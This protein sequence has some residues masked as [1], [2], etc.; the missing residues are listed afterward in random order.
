MLEDEIMRQT[1]LFE[2][3]MRLE[4]QMTLEDFGLTFEE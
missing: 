2:Y 3:G 4:G 1:T